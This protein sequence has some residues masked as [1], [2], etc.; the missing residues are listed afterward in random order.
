M[1]TLYSYSS[2]LKNLNKDSRII[3][4]IHGAGMDHTVWSSQKRYFASR[5]FAIIN[6]DLPGHGDNTEDELH[7]IEEMSDYVTNIFKD[8]EKKEVI[9]IG[10]SMGALIALDIGCRYSKI[11]DR[12]ILLGVS[13]EMNVHP[14][15]LNATKNDLF[16][17]VEKIVGWGLAANSKIG[18]AH[19]PGMWVPNFVRTLLSKVTTNTLGSDFAACNNYKNG[20]SSA[21]SIKC[22]VLIIS[23]KKDVMTPNYKG[24]ELA[25][26][27]K[28]S[29][30]TSI[31]DCGHM[32][33]LESP[34]EVN[35]AIS[36]E[37]V[38]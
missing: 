6:I 15:L 22:P 16:I 13:E 14:N 1:K 3:I 23:G 33:M 4:F 10:H 38:N 11:V 36:N 32:M 30:F 17:A 18:G 8:L 25:S 26:S 21:K 9:I 24:K 28:D 29:T 27:I 2:D 5:G 37:I 20:S 7:T 35:R 19:S 31:A 34:M 12:L